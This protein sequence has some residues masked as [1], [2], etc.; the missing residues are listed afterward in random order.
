MARF[1]C[2]ACGQE[3]TFVYQGR[4]EC[5]SCGSIDVQFALGVDELTDDD[6][7]IEAMTRLAESLGE[8]T[9]RTATSRFRCAACGQAGEHRWE[10]DPQA[11]QCPVCGSPD[12]VFTVSAITDELVDV[13]LDAE[14]ADADAS[15]DGS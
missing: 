13:L 8:S 3:D 1:R 2:R 12:V 11:H 10:P 4:H 15:K 7:R 5:P 9:E 14:A 6:P